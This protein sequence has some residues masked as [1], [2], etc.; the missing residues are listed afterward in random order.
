MIRQ[1]NLRYDGAMPLHEFHPFTDTEI[2]KIPHQPGVFLIFQVEVPVH[3]DGA[4][5][6]REAVRNVR[7]QYP[8]ATHFAVETLEGERAIGARLK[9]LQRELSRVRSATFFPVKPQ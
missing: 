5:D 9:T 4:K 7:S 2:A 3:V 1:G 6:L 8:A